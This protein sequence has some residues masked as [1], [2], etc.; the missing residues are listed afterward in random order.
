MPRKASDK[1]GTSDRK[2]LEKRIVERFKLV[3]QSICAE[4][5]DPVQVKEQM[6]QKRGIVIPS[7]ELAAQHKDLTRQREE[8]IEPHIQDA[9]N[10]L[11]IQLSELDARQDEEVQA[12]ISDYKQAMSDIKAKLT[13]T[14]REIANRYDAEKD[15]L[16]R[17]LEQVRTEELEKRAK[18][19]NTRLDELKKKEIITAETERKVEVEVQSRINLLRR[20]AGRITQIIEDSQNKVLEELLFVEERKAAKELI[21]KVPTVS[22][23]LQMLEKGP[24]GL[25]DL[26]AA[27]N[28]EVAQNMAALRLTAESSE[29][30]EKEVEVVEAVKVDEEDDPYSDSSVALEVDTITED[31]LDAAEA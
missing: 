2:A 4:Q 21:N 26:I 23:V 16:Q 31:E 24:E 7:T 14:K 19:I 22:V 28:P 20:Q 15:E 18:D 8:M 13:T 5:I 29:E 12:A 6:L 1:M 9:R 17:G 27:I 25:A 30:E 10:Q 3:K 11:R